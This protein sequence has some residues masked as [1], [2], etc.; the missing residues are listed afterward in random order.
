M[1]AA[2]LFRS[3]GRNLFVSATFIPLR[4]REIETVRACSFFARAEQSFIANIS[5]KKHQVYV[6]IGVQKFAQKEATG[7][8][9]HIAN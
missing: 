7:T 4:I 1:V 8:F 5:S 9:R 2:C 6:Q 3:L